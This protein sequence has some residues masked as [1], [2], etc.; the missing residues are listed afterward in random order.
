MHAQERP[1][2]ELS[3]QTG[4][5]LG[6][7]PRGASAVHLDVVVRRLNPIDRVNGNQFI[8]VAGFQG[9]PLRPARFAV[10]EQGLQAMG[11]RGIVERVA[12]FQSPLYGGPD[13]WLV[14]RFEQVIQ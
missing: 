10:V 7:N 8:P 6:K 5:R 13:T 3:L 9:Q 12:P 1:W 4:E 14:E 2:I 11:Q